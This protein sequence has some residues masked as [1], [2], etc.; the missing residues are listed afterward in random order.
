MGIRLNVLHQILGF[1]IFLRVADVNPCA[2][3]RITDD[4][5]VLGYQLLYQVGGVEECVIRYFVQCLTPDKIDAGVSIIVVFRLLY[6]PLDITSIKVEYAVWGCS[7]CRGGLYDRQAVLG[8][9]V[10]KLFHEFDAA[11]GP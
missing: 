11:N 3:Q 1:L 2:V 9:V 4:F 6:Q 10:E 7:R 5:A 8:D